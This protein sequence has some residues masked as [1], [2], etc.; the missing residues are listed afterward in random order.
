MPRSHA[1]QN[2]NRK[3]LG[4]KKWKNKKKQKRHKKKKH[5]GNLVLIAPSRR[6]PKGNAIRPIAPTSIG[7]IF[8]IK[9]PQ[10]RFFKKKGSVL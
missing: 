7:K 8:T 9:H 5:R 10:Q 3:K 2:K 6:T 4:R 1:R